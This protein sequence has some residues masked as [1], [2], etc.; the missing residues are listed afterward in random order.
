MSAM[1]RVTSV[2]LSEQLAIRLEE[3]AGALDRPRSWVIEQA[4]ARYVGEQAW[5]VTAISSA[6]NEY[7]AGATQP[8]AHDQVMQE[9]QQQINARL[10]DADPLA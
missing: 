9:L 4:I 5:Q 7:Q 10:G 2:R 1:A 6:L 3:L 8:I